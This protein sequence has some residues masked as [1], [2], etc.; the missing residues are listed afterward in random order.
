MPHSRAIGISQDPT[1]AWSAACDRVRS[2]IGGLPS[3]AGVFLYASIEAAL[4]EISLMLTE[5]ERELGGSKS[6]V[7]YGHLQDPALDRMAKTLSSVGLDTR[8]K[9]SSELSDVGTWFADVK[10]KALLI[11]FAEDDRFTGQVNDVAPIRTTVF[12]DGVRIPV[13]SVCFAAS[14]WRHA[15]PRPFEIRFYDLRVADNEF[16]TVAVVGERLRLEPRMAPLSL[17]E[18]RLARIEKALVDDHIVNPVATLAP[19]LQAAESQKARQDIENFETALP[20][21]FQSRWPA[22][23]LRLLDRA[24]ISTE[25]H[26]GS[27]LIERL[28]PLLQA[29]GAS[30]EQIEAGIFSLSGCTMNDERRQE[31]L[32]SRGEDAWATRGTLHIS[33]EL[34]RA[35]STEVWRVALEKAVLAAK[36]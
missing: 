13:L 9:K 2:Q 29:A 10:S 24:I 31:W 14:S 1:L 28:K 23:S 15:L 6:S 20:K 16:V 21:P 27:W 17:S 8:A 36:L 18:T 4:T 5:R 7:V 32:R 33:L 22:G 19:D 12:G 34:I 26:E 3:A 11:A 25:K 35:L 30:I